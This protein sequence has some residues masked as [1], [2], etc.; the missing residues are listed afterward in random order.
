MAQDICGR[1]LLAPYL[2]A[3]RNLSLGPIETASFLFGHVF[4]AKTDVAHGADLS[5]LM[6]RG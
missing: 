3:P 5:L 2:P 4:I 1:S 6:V